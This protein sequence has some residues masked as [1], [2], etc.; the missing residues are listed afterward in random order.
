MSKAAKRLQRMQA[1]LKDPN[2]LDRAN[3]SK[4]IDHTVLK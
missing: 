2:L 1:I 4:H 3:I